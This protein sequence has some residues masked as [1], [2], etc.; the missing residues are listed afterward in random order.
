MITFTIFKSSAGVLIPRAILTIVVQRHFQLQKSCS[1]SLTSG[2]SFPSHRLNT[3]VMI[4]FENFWITQ[5]TLYHRCPNIY[6]VHFWR[7]NENWME[8]GKSRGWAV[9][10][11]AVLGSRAACTRTAQPLDLP[12]FIQFLFFLQKCTSYIFG[13]PY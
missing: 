8:N 2:K 11:L 1:S 6:E 7:K 9:L 4:L 5:F 13:H 10:V 3:R 12:F